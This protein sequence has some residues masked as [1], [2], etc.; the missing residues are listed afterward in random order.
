MQ[1][2]DEANGGFSTAPKN[3][4]VR[5]VISNGEFGYKQLNV[6]RQQREPDSLLNWME[7]V[8]R[9]RKDCPEFGCGEWSLVDTGDAAVFAHCAR[10]RGGLVVAAHNLSDEPREVT[11]ALSDLDEGHVIDLLGDSD[12]EPPDGARKRVKLEGY[13][14]RW[15]RVG[16]EHRRPAN[17]RAGG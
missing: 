17:Q 6:E 10:W 8:I 12:Y 5:P 13:G 3:R 11:L 14:Y 9:L 16:G 15:F 2:S 4:L 7:K 1:W